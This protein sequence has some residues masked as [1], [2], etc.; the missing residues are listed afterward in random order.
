[1]T[2]DRLAR[3]GIVIALLTLAVVVVS[4][5]AGLQA[6][7][8]HPIATI[9]SIVLGG[10]MVWLIAKV[11]LTAER[12]TTGWT[13]SITGPNGKWLFLLLI[14]VW[15]AGMTFLASLGLSGLTIGGIAL[16]MLFVGFFLFMG[17]IWAV[18]GE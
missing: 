14:I 15:I 4:L 6:L 18:I 9:G 3:L 2:V 12:R 8:S 1:M 13:R 17:F 10:I 11:A 5:F 16:V 7:V